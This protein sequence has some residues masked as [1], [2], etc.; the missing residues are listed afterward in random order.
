MKKSFIVDIIGNIPPE[1]LK[2]LDNRLRPQLEKLGLT[3]EYRIAD[4][5]KDIST[6][7]HETFNGHM[8]IVYGMPYHL[9]Q[10]GS[11]SQELFGLREF[12]EPDKITKRKEY[13]KKI[14]IIPTN[15][16][17]KLAWESYFRYLPAQFTWS[18]MQVEL[19]EVQVI[20][21]NIAIIPSVTAFTVPETVLIEKILIPR[22]AQES[23]VY[24]LDEKFQARATK[25]Y[26]SV[27]PKTQLIFSDQYTDAL[28][29]IDPAGNHIIA[30]VISCASDL[31][32]ANEE[33]NRQMQEYSKILG[34]LGILY[35]YGGA[36]VGIMGLGAK[37]ARDAGARISAVIGAPQSDRYTHHNPPFAELSFLEN[38]IFTT[39]L[40]NRIPVLM[41]LPDIILMLPAGTGTFEELTYALADW[42]QPASKTT[43]KTIIIPRIGNHLYHVEK[44]LRELMDLKI[45]AGPIYFIN[46]P[47]EMVP[48]LEKLKAQKHQARITELNKEFQSLGM[49]SFEPKKIEQKKSVNREQGPGSTV[50]EK[51]VQIGAWKK[52]AESRDV[53][54][55]RCHTAG[56]SEIILDKKYKMYSLVFLGDSVKSLYAAIQHHQMLS[57]Y[58]TNGSIPD[59]DFCENKLTLYATNIHRQ[60][61]AAIKEVLNSIYRLI[62]RETSEFSSLI[63]ELNKE[64]EPLGMHDVEFKLKD[65]KTETSNNLG[66]AVGSLKKLG[67]MTSLEA[68]TIDITDPNREPLSKPGMHINSD[69]YV[70]FYYEKK[71]IS[72]L[73]AESISNDQFKKLQ[74]LIQAD[75][76]NH[77]H[78]SHFFA[79]DIWSKI[80]PSTTYQN[81]TVICTS[82]RLE[83]S[84]KL[85]SDD[86]KY[87]YRTDHNVDIRLSNQDMS[88]LGYKIKE[89]LEDCLYRRGYF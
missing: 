40:Q 25:K 62:R 13:P 10:F 82:I 34:Q 55:Y 89:M 44:H 28:R 73:L 1:E 80:T 42:V 49:L 51:T 8:L 26:R 69:Y 79:K 43:K 35:V 59:I 19:P 75:F 54:S 37:A 41:K 3:S 14:Y 53:I 58:T 7:Y 16:R 2:K 38:F 88:L 84:K 4:E 56:I 21:A 46:E 52:I 83:I 76:V 74:E 6:V 78:P 39:S 66:V 24:T 22:E 5:N 17:E 68:K 30:T 85:S 15:E 47:R 77:I 65:Y 31:K 32:P 18:G 81:F 27:W 71:I 87:I 86:S 11:L 60:S 61:P 70:Y 29:K 63:S 23:L 48:I 36:W 33:H 72:L 64:L 67:L 45:L 9:P 12:D 20:L 57:P 50:T